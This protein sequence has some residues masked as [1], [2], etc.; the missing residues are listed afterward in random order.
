M[1]KSWNER[2]SLAESELDKVKSENR[3]GLR[4]THV[5]RDDENLAQARKLISDVQDEAMET[6]KVH[7]LLNDP[8]KVHYWRPSSSQQSFYHCDGADRESMMVREGKLR[9][10]VLAET[11]VD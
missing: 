9:E 5:K 8:F 4:D 11:A 10:L 2:L 3:A 6:L 7:D 1:V